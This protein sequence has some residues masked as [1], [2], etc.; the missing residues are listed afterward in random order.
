MG[1]HDYAINDF[2]K[3]I[4]IDPAYANARFFCGISK[5]KSK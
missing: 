4:E 1:N 5:L 3:A 2:N